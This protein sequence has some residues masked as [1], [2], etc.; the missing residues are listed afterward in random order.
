MRQRVRRFVFALLAGAFLTVSGA[1]SGPRAAVSAPPPPT[2]QVATVIQKN[3]SL[4]SEWI[5]TMDGYV[6][7]QIQP[8][9]S[10]YLIR[11][12]YTEGSAVRKGDVLFE[13][14]P[15]PFQA[16]LDQAKAQF[17]Q[18]QAQLTQAEA[19]LGKARQDVVRVIRRSRRP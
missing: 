10:G 5:A 15:R 16:T 4:S 2:V 3:V 7:A 17:K 12:N 19:Q 1:C 13:I 14:D 9:L 6:N 11:Q 8:H 18:A